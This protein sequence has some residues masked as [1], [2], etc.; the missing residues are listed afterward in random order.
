MFPVVLTPEQREVERGHVHPAQRM[1]GRLRTVGVGFNQGM[2][3][4]ARPGIGVAVDEQ[5][6]AR[7]GH[8][9]A[10]VK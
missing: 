4:V 2:D 3:E 10:P 5:D 1:P 6:A 8:G 9:R 7:F